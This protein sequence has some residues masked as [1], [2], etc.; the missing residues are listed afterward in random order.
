VDELD[1]LGDLSFS[2][3]DV[4]TATTKFFFALYRQKK[5]I[6]MF[7]AKYNIYNRKTKTKPPPLKKLPPTEDNLYLH[8][9][10]A[11]LQV[12]LWKSVNKDCAPDDTRDITR[13]GWVV[14]D[15]TTD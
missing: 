7:D 12:M 6:T 3:D 2:Y 1:H 13:Y 10:R 8:G 9:R 15:C 14:K 4:K 11:H 5:S